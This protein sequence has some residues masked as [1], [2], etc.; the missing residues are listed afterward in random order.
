M[1]RLLVSTRKGA[2]FLS[3]D[4]KLEGPIFFGSIVDHLLVD[5]RDGRTM[6]AGVRTGHLGPTVFRSDDEGRTWKEAKRPPA[7]P[8]GTEASVSAVF[9]LTPGHA[10]EPRTWY[11][12]SAPH[13][14]FRSEDGGDTWE[15]VVGFLAWRETLASVPGRVGGTPGGE[16]THSVLVDPRDPSHLYVGLS[17][18]GFFESRD[19]GES[20]R[21][22]NQGVAADFLP[23]DA[24]EW[25][26]DPHCVVLHPT[27]PDR[28][29]QQNHC[30][31]YRLDRP[32][33]TWERIGK[34]MPAEVGDI[35]FPIAVHPRDPDT[36]WVFPMDG[37]TVWP[38]TSPGGRPAVYRTTDAGRTWERQ[39]RCLPKEQGWFTVLR[40]AFAVDGGT[41]VGLYFGTTSGEIWGS[42]DE[43]GSWRQLAAHLPAIV[44]VEAA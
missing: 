18:A 27:R 42:A 28:L 29:Y 31:I 6:V 13:G 24:P 36:A 26:H 3:G 41:P 15:P 2:W 43:G 37:T 20:W 22:L 44:A 23:D 16:L 1:K 14:L 32:G 40:Q 7:F 17:T 19:R 10:D 30:G 33:E 34:A 9:W 5:P 25:G 8:P 4:G 12:G 38:R 39:D 21:A 35:G 11:A